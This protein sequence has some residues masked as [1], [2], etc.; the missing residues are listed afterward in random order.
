MCPGPLTHPQHLSL[1][2]LYLLPLC[3]SQI[4]GNW[5][6]LTPFFKTSPSV[7]F[8]KGF[9]SDVLPEGTARTQDRFHDILRDLWKE[10]QNNNRTREKKKTFSKCIKCS[11]FIKGKACGKMVTQWQTSS[12]LGRRVRVKGSR[13]CLV[14]SLPPSLD[15][16]SSS[17]QTPPFLF[18]IALWVR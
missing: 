14:L 10:Q 9:A 16:S 8:G 11:D 1:V 13:M 5:Y 2:S 3:K 18:N 6:R 17:S 7:C 12:Y 4:L 15:T